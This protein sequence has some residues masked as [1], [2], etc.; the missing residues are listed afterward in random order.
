VKKLLP[1]KSNK[2]LQTFPNPIELMA[3]FFQL[4]SSGS[5]V[6]PPAFKTP[7]GT[8]ITTCVA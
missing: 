3:Y 5:K 6:M 4:G 7:R 2:I 1:V 8:A